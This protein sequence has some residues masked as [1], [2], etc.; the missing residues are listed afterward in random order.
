MLKSK[1][2]YWI[3][4]RGLRSDFVA[5][6]LNVS[7]AQVSKWKKGKAHPRVEKLFKLARLLNVKV[8]DLYE[9]I[10]HIDTTEKEDF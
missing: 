5:G 7:Q 10:D 9:E 2:A 8:D 6:E 4:K 3:D 1:I